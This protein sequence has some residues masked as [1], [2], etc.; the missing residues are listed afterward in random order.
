MTFDYEKLERELEIAC[1]EVHK[2]FVKRFNDG[3]YI[4]VGGAKLEAFF[5]EMQKEFETAALEFLTRRSLQKNAQARK[6]ALAITK[7][8]AKKCVD[9]FSKVNRDTAAE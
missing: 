7:L 4:S 3:V 2:D 8:Y 6:R 9:D 5:N 1:D